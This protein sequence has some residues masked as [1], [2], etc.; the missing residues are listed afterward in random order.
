MKKR[1]G[2]ASAPAPL[3]ISNEGHADTIA[4]ESGLI[5]PVLV[6]RHGCSDCRVRREV[7]CPSWLRALDQVLLPSGCPSQR[8]RH[9]SEASS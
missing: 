9:G 6:R 2:G 8:F 7:L 4:D 1:Q 3:S 5:N